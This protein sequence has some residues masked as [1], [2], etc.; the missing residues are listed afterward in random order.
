MS[1]DCSKLI[2][3]AHFINVTNGSNET[4]SQIL[5]YENEDEFMSSKYWNQLSFWTGLIIMFII[6]IIIPIIIIICIY[7]KYDKYQKNLKLRLLK[8]ESTLRTDCKPILMS[9]LTEEEYIAD[10]IMDYSNIILSSSNLESIMTSKIKQ[11]KCTKRLIM[12]K[13]LIY[14]LFMILLII[15]YIFTYHIT[16]H[17]KDSY[18]SYI[19][20]TCY[21]I[22]DTLRE[23]NSY[24]KAKYLID[25]THICPMDVNKYQFISATD[26]E[27]DKDKSYQPCFVNKQDFSIRLMA[28]T[29]CKDQARCGK[30]GMVLYCILTFLG[31]VVTCVSCGYCI[32]GIL[33]AVSKTI[34]LPQFLMRILLMMK[35]MK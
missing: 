25:M 11:T 20:T 24:Y 19:E 33:R 5:I 31:C 3:T 9:H 15:P 13:L 10:L 4:I 32:V 30:D 22:D 6:A 2:N 28:N 23:R 34:I 27:A 12:H 18:K 21:V 29:C 26:L 8:V 16:A 14:W 1:I 7:P 17:M 35:R